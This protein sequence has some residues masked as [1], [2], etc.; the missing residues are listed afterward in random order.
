MGKVGSEGKYSGLSFVNKSA[1]D[2]GSLRIPKLRI[3]NLVAKFPII[4]GVW[5]SVSPWLIWLR[6]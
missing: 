4:Q 5:G 3:G 1:K 6:L 2:D